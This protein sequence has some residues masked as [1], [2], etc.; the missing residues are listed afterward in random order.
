MYK[1]SFNESYG[2]PDTPIFELYYATCDDLCALFAEDMLVGCN[3]SITFERRPLTKE[4]LA[5]LVETLTNEYCVRIVWRHG[6]WVLHK[7]YT[8]MDA[9][10]YKCTLTELPDPRRA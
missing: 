2:Y 5:S 8:D 1:L 7:G 3:D 6:N 9:W 10:E 4:F